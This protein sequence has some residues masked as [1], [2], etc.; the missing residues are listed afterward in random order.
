[1]RWTIAKAA[2]C[3]CAAAAVMVASDALSG[4]WF[5]EVTHEAGIHHKHS[6]RV[7]EN[8]YAA[9]MSGYTALGASAAV[10]DFDGDGYDDGD[11]NVGEEPLPDRSR[12]GACE[13]TLPL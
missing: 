7:F 3:F 8:P 10:A 9:I 12:S 2:V 5:R 1:M 4:R 13:H 6:N 11:G